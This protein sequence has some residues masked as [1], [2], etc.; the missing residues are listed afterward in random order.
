[1][2]DAPKGLPSAFETKE[3]VEGFLHNLEKLKAD[4]SVTEEQYEIA[5]EEYQQRLTAAIREIDHIKDGLRK[6]LESNQQDIEE[7]RRELGE[8]KARYEA[9][10]VPLE[11]YR[12]SSLE[13]QAEL[14]GLEGDGHALERLL[15]ARSSSDIGAVTGRAQ[16]AVPEYR[17]T[18]AATGAPGV[19]LG[20]GKLLGVVG[21][22]AVVGVVVAMLL[23]GPPWAGEES[24]PQEP[25]GGVQPPVAEE[26][27]A[28]SPEEG[29]PVATEEQEALEV[30]IPIQAQ[31][32]EYVGSLHV[33]L[34]Y[35]ATVLEATR[36]EMGELADDA[37]IEYN[38]DRPGQVVIGVISGT[39]MSGSGAAAAVT[40]EVKGAGN[41]TSI[42]D[43]HN[44]AA[45]DAVSLAEIPTG[46]LSGSFATEDGAFTSPIL[47]FAPVEG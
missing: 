38:V 41:A 33:E 13:L 20:R 40:F 14:D 11:D 12:N 39:G 37:M 19:R 42:L 36:V 32:A 9:G 18:G 7:C 29:V 21:G 35:D 6:Q 23:L 46:V 34:A 3:Q 10:E 47:V 15:A 25:T 8:L 16:A 30:H 17:A 5:R 1:M 22:V 31:D 2:A 45:H 27:A 44:V 28:P 4:G 24:A 26:E 43:L